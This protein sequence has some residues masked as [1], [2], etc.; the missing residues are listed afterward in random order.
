[1]SYIKNKF[2]DQI[3]INGSLDNR[4]FNN[5]YGVTFVVEDKTVHIDDFIESADGLMVCID[6]YDGGRETYVI[7][8]ETDFRKIVWHAE[9]VQYPEYVYTDD[10]DEK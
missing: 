4:D 3:V 7:M 1:M 5:L 6:V 10:D 9:N 2:H 8:D